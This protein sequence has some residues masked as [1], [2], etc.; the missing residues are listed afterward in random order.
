MAEIRHVTQLPESLSSL[1]EALC[2]NPWHCVIAALRDGDKT[3]TSKL[4]LTLLQ[5]AG[6]NEIHETLF[7]GKQQ[8]QLRN[9][10]KICK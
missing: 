10:A 4:S 8:Q 2:F 7:Q 9:N 5:A 3:E 1:Q 6:Q